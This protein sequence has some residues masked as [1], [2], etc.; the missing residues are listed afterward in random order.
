MGSLLNDAG[1]GASE[2][3]FKANM[4]ANIKA[5]REQALK[6]NKFFG[7]NLGTEAVEFDDQEL[8]D[9]IFDEKVWDTNPDFTMA[10]FLKSP[11]L[12]TMLRYAA[13]LPLVN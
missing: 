11:D 1:K 2:A 9:T 12:A 8:I 3:S 5:K 6:E 7:L 10:V 4:N 13:T